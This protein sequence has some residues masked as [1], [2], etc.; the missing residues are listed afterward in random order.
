MSEPLDLKNIIEV[1]EIRKL[2]IG[3]PDLLSLF[4]MVIIIANNRINEEKQSK[5]PPLEDNVE[6]DLSD[7]ESDED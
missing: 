3:H 7:H 1:E 4:E 5:D 6:P 2:L